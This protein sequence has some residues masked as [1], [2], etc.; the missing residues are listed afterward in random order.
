M[1]SI[2]PNDRPLPFRR[3]SQ[4]TPRDHDWLWRWRFAFGKLAMLDGDAG[5]GKS[6]VA[7]D[8]C[9]RL[10]TG[11]PMPDGSPGPGPMDALIIQDED[12]AEDTVTHRLR[13]LGADIERISIWTA[14]TDDD[15]FAIPSQL[16]LLERMIRAVGARLV[17]ID[18]V[19][20]YLDPHVFASS[21]QAIRRA[22]RPLKELA[23]RCRCVILMVRHFAKNLRTR[24]LYR[25]LGSVAFTNLCRCTWQVGRDPQHSDR[26]ILVQGKNTL[27]ARQPSLAYRLHGVE[28]AVGIEWLGESSWTAEQ[29]GTR[30]PTPKL[31]RAT[32]FLEDFLKDGPRQIHEI[33]TAARA[34][35]ISYR[36][37]HRAAKS[38]KIRVR[39]LWRDRV[40]YCYWLL[41]GQTVPLSATPDDFDRYLADIERQRSAPQ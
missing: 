30:Q 3:V 41:D 13:A 2:R 38:M 10:S 17:V 5:E 39:R 36:T 16:E 15:Q 14:D 8:L 35:H 18:P 6:L 12:G 11:R 29:L 25:G 40:Q 1:S 7:L 28:P 34:Q 23:E 9:A 26:R 24:A 4:I 22:F 32:A 27:T 20:A 37:L 33:R 21:E 19:L 31:D